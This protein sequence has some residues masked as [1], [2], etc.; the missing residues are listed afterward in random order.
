[1]KFTL[2]L[3]GL[4]AATQRPVWS[5]RSVLDHR[6]DQ[7]VQQA[8][9]DH[10]ITKANA[11]DPY[12]STLMQLDGDYFHVYESGKE[13][14]GA[15][16]RALPA[17]FSADTDDLFMRSM[18]ANYA[19]E[20]KNC[21]DDGKNCVPSGKFFLNKAGALQ[22]ANEVLATH[23]AMSGADLE[24]YIGTYFD[25]AWG[26]FDVNR[27]G[28]IEVQKAPQLMRFLASDQRMSLG[29]NGF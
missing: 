23:K 29:E 5:L 6:V 2:A 20:G 18:I 19:L 17:R 15:Y 4:A 27:V 21:D 12:D 7:G 8:Y 11:R 1:M 22:A 25:K 13:F 28:T 10:S 14:N 9:G 24:K 3:A 16:N 26:H